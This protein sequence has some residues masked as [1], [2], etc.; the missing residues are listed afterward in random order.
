MEKYMIAPVLI[1]L[2]I[3]VFAC[4]Y[5]FMIAKFLGHDEESQ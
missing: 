3:A 5:T 1:F 2:A 4:G